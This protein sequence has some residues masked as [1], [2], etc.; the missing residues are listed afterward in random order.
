MDKQLVIQC[1]NNQASFLEYLKAQ[2]I[3][4]IFVVCG[5]SAHALE[6]YKVLKQYEAEGGKIYEFNDY[7]PNPSWDSVIAGI[8]E[9]KKFGSRNILA[10]GGGSPMDVAKCIKLF[11]NSDIDTEMDPESLKAVPNEIRFMVAPTT[12]GS[13]SE[14]TRFSVI[15]K[16]GTKKSISDDMALP[17][18]IFMDPTV[19]E[20]LP[21]YQKKATLMDALSHSIESYWSVA[22][23]EESRG[24]SEL[25]IKKILEYKNAYLRGDSTRECADMLNASDISYKEACRELLLASMLAGK[26]INITKTT[27]GHAMCYKLTTKYGFSHGHSASLVNSRLW[28][29][30]LEHLDACRESISKDELATRL[31]NLGN[32]FGFLTSA[33]AALYFKNL[34]CTY[35]FEADFDENKKQT[36][37]DL[38]ELC[39]AVNISRLM[40]NPVDLS[41]EA[42][43]ELYRE[44]LHI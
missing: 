20:S 23:T 40:N 33:E 35:G 11:A 2:N 42:V 27:A 21:M 18:V 14:A 8:C 25:A 7:T 4:S 16:N 19:L 15:Y 31:E 34:V 24:Y 3:E 30:M 12:A 22:S 41:A 38:E 13:G 5:K 1:E 37:A 10:I 28:P 39:S 44:I 32:I 9:F 43:E 26:A 17:S 36:E 29:Y 6:I